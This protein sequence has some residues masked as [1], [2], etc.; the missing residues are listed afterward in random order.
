MSKPLI[1]KSQINKKVVWG[2]FSNKN[3]LIFTILILI[4]F[5][6]S[7]RLGIWQYQRHE[8]RIVF[9]QA[10]SQ[11]LT[12]QPIALNQIDEEALSWQK[13]FIEGSFDSQSQQLV[14]RKYFEGKLGFWVV[15][16][17]VTQ[18]NK[19]VLVNRGFVPV[20]AAATVTPDI[21]APSESTFV[22]E[23]FIQP[24]EPE[25]EKASDI[26]LGQA[27]AINRQQF[28]IT[29][30]DYQYFIHQSN[31][32]ELSA[33]NP[34]EI[35]NGPHLAYSLQWFAFAVMIVVGWIVISRKD[36]IEQD[37]IDN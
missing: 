27:S 8:A 35:S 31:N 13:V 12:Q 34:P 36:L 21:P 30:K 19:V 10:I 9:N 29:E 28:S 6:L 11:A 15:A 18:D 14:R 3:W 23:G 7:I 25:L 16:K 26:P 22:L 33:I 37:Q 17:F 1:P 24:L 4:A 32:E 20:S 2:L 5:G